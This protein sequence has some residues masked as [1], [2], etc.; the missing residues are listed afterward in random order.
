V[1][2]RDDAESLKDK[3]L[4]VLEE[5]AHNTQRLLG[6]L[7]ALTQES[8]IDAHAALF[9]ILTRVAFDESS[10]R[11][12]WEAVVEHRETLSEALGREVAVRVA[13]LDYFVNVNRRLVQPNLI[14]VEMAEVD[15]RDGEV[16][17]ITGLATDRRFRTALQNELRRAKRYGQKAAVALFD[18][19]AFARIN[20]RFGT[21]VG[22]RLLRELAILANNH[23]RDIDVAARPAEDEIALLLPETDR[24]GCLLVA[25]R[26]RKEVEAFFARR[27]SAGRATELTVSG[28]VACYPDDASTPEALLEH[29]AQALYIAKA[30]GKNSVQAF[31]PERRR[32]LRFELEPGRF[33]VEVLVPSEHASG[34]LRN[35]SR[36][37]VLF[38]CP[39]RLEVG[40]E[41]EIRVLEPDQT[42]GHRPLRV[43]G[44][45]V[46]LEE[47]PEP[48][49]AEADAGEPVSASSADRYD[50]GVALDLE[51]TTGTSDVLDLLERARARGAGHRA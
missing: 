20:E 45:V 14:D 31:S 4:A 36:C 17:R 49:A 38:S 48:L 44:R 10:A 13:L 28:G 27:E 21:L 3:L 1:I 12:H 51:W 35:L 32:Y 41:I 25:E 50:V 22:D 43:R 16:D 40:E 23:V 46:R 11:R 24:N 2:T 47:L 30:S 6:R 34:G 9:L 33:E 8:G 19:D 29:A 15:L 42:E 26:F 5:D 7:D 39:E 37:G 18:I